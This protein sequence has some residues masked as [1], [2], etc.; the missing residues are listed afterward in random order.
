MVKS[1]VAKSKS[2]KRYPKEFRRQMVELYRAG[3]RSDGQRLTVATYPAPE[4]KAS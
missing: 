3:K 1:K 2:A 4:V